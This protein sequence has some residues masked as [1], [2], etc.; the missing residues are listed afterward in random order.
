MNDLRERRIS[1]LAMSAGQR[2]ALALIAA[3]VL[4]ALVAWA[5]G[6]RS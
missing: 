2:L 6:A 4:W 3:G 1:L 5:L